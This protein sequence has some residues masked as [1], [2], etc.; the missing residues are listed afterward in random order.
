MAPRAEKPPVDYV[1]FDLGRHLAQH[2][3]RWRTK[4]QQLWVAGKDAG[5]PWARVLRNNHLGWV[6]R[7]TTDTLA[8]HVQCA[9]FR[10]AAASDH[11]VDGEVEID[12]GGEVSFSDEGAYVQAWV[13]VPRHRA[14]EI[15]KSQNIKLPESE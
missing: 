8:Y 4:L 15:L 5:L 9:A 2:G 12:D 6:R 10:T 11:H 7:Q 1:L 3:R 13:W 14:E